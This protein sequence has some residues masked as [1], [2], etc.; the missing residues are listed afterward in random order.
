[1]RPKRLLLIDI[2]VGSSQIHWNPRNSFIIDGIRPTCKICCG[3]FFAAVSPDERHHIT[4]ARIRHCRQIDHGTVAEWALGSEIGLRSS[5]NVQ[6][7]QGVSGSIRREAAGRLQ[8]NEA[9]SDQNAIRRQSHHTH[10]HRHAADDFTTAQR[11]VSGEISDRK[12]RTFS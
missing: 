8:P 5:E 11:A 9:I 12:V 10:V 7:R 3:D 1:M 4:N 6:R 2:F